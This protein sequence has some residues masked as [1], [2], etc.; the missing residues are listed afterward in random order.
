M[1]SWGVFVVSAL[2]LAGADPAPAT[3]ESLTN[4]APVAVKDTDASPQSDDDP[5]GRDDIIVTGQRNDG[6]RAEDTNALGIG[7]D[8]KET[9]ATVNVII[10]QF[11]HDTGARRLSDIIAYTPGVVNNEKSTSLSEFYIVRGFATSLT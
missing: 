9:P 7:L 11:I 8:L 10:D 2:S 1:S 5:Q 6:Y 4:D 3:R